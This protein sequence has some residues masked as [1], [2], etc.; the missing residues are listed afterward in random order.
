MSVQRVKQNDERTASLNARWIEG[1]LVIEAPILIEKYKYHIQEGLLRP[2][3]PS[4]FI[5]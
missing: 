3:A 2:P 5:N 4:S 1:V